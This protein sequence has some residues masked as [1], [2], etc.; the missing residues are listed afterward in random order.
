MRY[1]HL[2]P[3]AMLEAVN[4]VGNI[5]GRRQV[6]ANQAATVVAMA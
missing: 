2:S 1:A 3:Q 6:M 4:V 5:V